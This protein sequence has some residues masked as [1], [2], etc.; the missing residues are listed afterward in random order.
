MGNPIVNQGMMHMNMDESVIHV[1]EKQN[2]FHFQS[3]YDRIIKIKTDIHKLSLLEQ[4][5]RNKQN[6]VRNNVFSTNNTSQNV[7]NFSS[8]KNNNFNGFP[9][10]N[11]SSMTNRS[12]FA[13]NLIF[14]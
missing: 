10:A 12:S 9:S 4:H 5:E 7:M 8:N 6:A 3:K 11:T 2:E 13:Q 1:K 14:T